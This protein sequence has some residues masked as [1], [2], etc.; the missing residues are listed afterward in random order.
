MS[1]W[2][3]KNDG[4]II[5]FDNNANNV[6]RC[7]IIYNVTNTVFYIKSTIKS[8]TTGFILRSGINLA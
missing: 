5:V 1:S 4:T 6:N 2:Y 3:D 8:T 7:T